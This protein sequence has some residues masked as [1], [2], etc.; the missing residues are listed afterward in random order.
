MRRG[1]CGGDLLMAPRR[2]G[3]LRIGR[4][5][6]RPRQARLL[7]GFKARGGGAGGVGF[8]FGAPM[9]FP[10][11]LC[12]RRHAGQGS[13]FGDLLGARFLVRKVGGTALGSGPLA[14]QPDQLFLFFG[15]GSGR[16]CQFG[17]GG[18][19]APG[20][21]QGALFRLDPRSQGDFGQ[22]FGMGLLRGRGFGCGLGGGTGARLFGGEIFGLLAPL[23]C[24]N[25]L[26]GEQVARLGSDTGALLGGRAPKRRGFGRPLGVRG[27][28]GGEIVPDGQLAAQSIRCHQICQDSAQVRLPV[29]GKASSA[30]SP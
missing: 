24:G 13:R 17:G 20:V 10:R 19:T 11:R 15:A 4:H 1:E 3:G 30:R 2:R 25:L 22:T 16:G 18:F 7:L 8:L 14:S 9:R 6:L 26:A 21:R 23:R 29:P 28:R 5:A 12:F 27:V